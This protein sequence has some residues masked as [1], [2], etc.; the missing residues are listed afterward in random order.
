MSD[1]LPPVVLQAGGKG[2]RMKAGGLAVPKVLMPVRGIP[3]LERL[4]RQLA[5][6]GARQFFIIIGHSGDIVEAHVR[7][8]SDLPPGVDLTF[9][10][11]SEARGNAGS[12]AE[13]QDL[14]TPVLFSFGD[15]YTNLKFRALYALH[16]ERGSAITAASH[17]E[18]HR[19]QLGQ[20]IVEQDRIVDYRE[21]PEY[22][23]LICSG[24]MALEPKVLR[25]L[26]RAGMVG[27]NRLV[28][29]A[30]E[31]GFEVTHW[32][33]GASWMDVNTP[34]LLSTANQMEL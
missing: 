5:A 27:M 31:A 7:A 12:L 10:R 18:T 1:P 9:I 33:H 29:L 23:F 16:R 34:E 19:L 26:P 25:L 21:K 11:E 32:R 15:L 8:M 28:L 24:I 14:D 3:L 17:F 22:Q 6:E 13:L 4:I 20:I 2:E 30:I